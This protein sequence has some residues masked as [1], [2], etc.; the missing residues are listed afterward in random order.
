MFH[1]ALRNVSSRLLDVSSLGCRGD[2]PWNKSCSEPTDANG[3]VWI[4]DWV[5][6]SNKLSL[7]DE[8]RQ[9]RESTTLFLIQ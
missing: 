7:Y 9:Q 4:S 8:P 6:T 3:S 1:A 2:I 5:P